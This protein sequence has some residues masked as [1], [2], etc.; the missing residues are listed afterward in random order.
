M[1]GTRTPLSIFTGQR[2]QLRGVT[3]SHGILRPNMVESVDFTPKLDL[4]RIPEWDNKIDA[5]IF[6]IFGGGSGKL[7]YD[8]SNQGQL[9]A[10]IMDLDP[11][12]EFT[13]L[14]P[15]NFKPFTVFANMK[16]LDEKIKGAFLLYGGVAH[17]N[18]FTGPVK[19]SAKMTVDFDYLN[20]LM[21]NGA[22]IL[23]TR[24]TGGVPQVGQSTAPVLV[25]AAA[26]TLPDD[27]YYVRIVGKTATGQAL[28]SKEVA[29]HVTGGGGTASVTVTTAA[30]AGSIASYDVYAYNRSNGERFAGNDAGA[31]TFSLTSL[32]PS[33]A[34]PVTNVDTSG[35]FTS[36]ADKVFVGQAITLDQPA[37]FDPQSGLAYALV[38]KN[39][40]ILAS[41]DNPATEDTFLITADGTQVTLQ[42]APADQDWWDIFTF[43]AIP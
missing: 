8:R 34:A 19:D 4:K 24:A 43:Y 16:G 32:P 13:V 18:P 17:G 30:P 28:P 12:Q 38:M 10:L 21:V 36:S 20:G 31:G 29:V 39:G 33:S 11:A 35:T 22:G 14:N 42:A 40:Q 1:A 41:M 27:T 2:G 6:T 5:L 23:H 37:V 7:G 15:S 9:D 3:Q 26:G 25:Q